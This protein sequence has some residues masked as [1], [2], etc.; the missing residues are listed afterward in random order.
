M[1]KLIQY[2]V[3]SSHP[4]GLKFNV[5]QTPAYQSWL[6]NGGTGNSSSSYGGY[7]TGYSSGSS[8]GYGTRS[9]NSSSY[10]SG[11]SYSTSGRG[12]G[13]RGYGGY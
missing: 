2:K 3:M 1:L 11:S 7:G 9:T 8:G 5:Y 6:A 12:Y 4:Y 13:G 10:G